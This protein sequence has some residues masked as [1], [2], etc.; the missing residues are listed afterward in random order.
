[1][2]DLRFASP[3]FRRGQG[4]V[5]GTPAIGVIALRWA[6]S[7]PLKNSRMDALAVTAFAQLY[8]SVGTLHSAEIPFLESRGEAGNGQHCTASSIPASQ[9]I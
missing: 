4:P 2:R 9:Q 7:L 1:M 6:C 8:R 5:A 3:H